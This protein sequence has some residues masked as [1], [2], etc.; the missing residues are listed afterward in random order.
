ML[1]FWNWFYANVFG[2]LIASMIAG[3][4]V[5]LWARRHMKL[6]H[7]KID[8]VH[9]ATIRGIELQQVIHG[10]H[11]GIIKRNDK[12]KYEFDKGSNTWTKSE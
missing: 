10:I 3:S 2:N 5:W 9:S 7:R 12:G 4:A 8:L 6:L 11:T 1:A